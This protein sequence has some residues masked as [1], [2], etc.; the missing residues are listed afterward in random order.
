M[1]LLDAFLAEATDPVTV[2]LSVAAGILC[3]R[4]WHVAVACLAI[5]IVG[6]DFCCPAKS[7]V[8]PDLVFGSRTSTPAVGV[9]D[10]CD[11][12]I[13]RHELILLSSCAGTK[14]SSRYPAE[15]VRSAS[16]PVYEDTLLT[17][18]SW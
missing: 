15:A 13:S 6:D 8:Q 17:Q 12:E 11:E 7:Q 10:T 2:S 14:D 3:R 16:P 9:P 5:M 18:A 1:Y 4:W